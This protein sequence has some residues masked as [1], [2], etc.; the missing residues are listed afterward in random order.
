MEKLTLDES[1]VQVHGNGP[2]L[3]R[4]DHSL[5][6]F[7]PVEEVEGNMVLAGLPVLQLTAISMD[8]Q[9]LRGQVIGQAP[10]A[11]R[12]LRPSEPTVSE[13]EAFS[14]WDR[15]RNRFVNLREVEIHRLPS[16]GE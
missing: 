13:D 1:V 5:E 16:L 6:V 9:P 12:K 2:T 3:E 8:P 11:L 10:C 7:I 4:A 14:V 15:S